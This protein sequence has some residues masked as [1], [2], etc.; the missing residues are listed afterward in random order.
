MLSDF[1]S[2]SYFFPTIQLRPAAGART[3][4]HIGTHRREYSDLDPNHL[5]Y[6]Q[7]RLK[8]LERCPFVEDVTLAESRDTYRW[9]FELYKRLKN[10]S[11]L[12]GN[13]SERVRELS[14]NDCIPRERSHSL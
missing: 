2:R 7:W 5:Y 3:L 6:M 14:R 12:V 4:L 9:I 13:T 8:G 10:T 11:M 1:C